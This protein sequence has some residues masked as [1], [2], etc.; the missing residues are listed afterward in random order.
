MPLTWDTTKIKNDLAWYKVPNEQLKKEQEE[1]LSKA[2]RTP[3]FGNT[4]EKRG[5]EVYEMKTE[6]NLLILLSMNIGMN[7]ITEKNYHRFFG[8]LD[9]FQRLS[10]NG[11]MTE[12]VIDENGNKTIQHK[13]YTL[14]MIKGFIGLKTNASTLT[15]KEFIKM[16][17]NKFEI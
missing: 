2:Y 13:L 5:D 15:A 16:I 4:R 12:E 7:E 9:M 10:G 8:R 1:K 14:D 3:I 11:F 17:T 6:L